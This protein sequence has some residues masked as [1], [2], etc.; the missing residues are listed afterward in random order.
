MIRTRITRM[1]RM[2]RMIRQRRYGMNSGV[3]EMLY[4][5]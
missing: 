1:I 5:A 3:V 2:I 4:Y